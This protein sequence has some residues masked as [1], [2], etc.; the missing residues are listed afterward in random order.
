[1]YKCI[2][3]Y[4]NLQ[5]ICSLIHLHIYRPIYILSYKYIHTHT[6]ININI[7]IYRNI[8]GFML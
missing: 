8:V 6:Y 5:R 4:I 1:M 3:I 7:Y 2:N